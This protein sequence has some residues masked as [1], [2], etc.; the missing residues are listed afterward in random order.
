MLNPAHAKAAV[1]RE[2]IDRAGIAFLAILALAVMYAYLPSLGHGPRG[3]QWP[4]LM[5]MMHQTSCGDYI[6][7][8][9]S[10]NRTRVILPGDTAL[11]RPLLFAYL[12][13]MA[14]MSGTHVWIPQAAGI[15]LH[16]GVAGLAFTVLRGL[17]VE[18]YANS[19]IANGVAALAALYFATTP[20]IMEQVIWA[21]VNAYMLASLC[22]LG[23]IR[24]Q[25]D[26]AANDWIAPRQVAVTLALAVIACFTFEPALFL[27]PLLAL[28]AAAGW[29]PAGKTPATVR[30][31]LGLAMLYLAP[32]VVYLGAYLLDQHIHPVQQDPWMNSLG[33]RAAAVETLI[34][35]A[36]YL[37]YA[38]GY[39]FVA[40]KPEGYTG[41]RLFVSE[42]SAVRAVLAAVLLACLAAAIIAGGNAARHLSGRPRRAALL[43]GAIALGLLV[44]QALMF[45]V[46]RINPNPTSPTVLATSSY[47][48][49]APY[50][51][52]TLL[53]VIAS[54]CMTA[55]WTN[56]P[57]SARPRRWLVRM[58]IVLAVLAIGVRAG[59]VHSVN[60]QLARHLAPLVDAVDAINA[61]RARDPFATFRISAHTA[62]RLERFQGVPVLYTLFHHAIDQCGARYEILPGSPYVTA[63]TAASACYP[64]LVRP[65]TN[66]HYYFY[67]GEYFG[68]PFWFAFPNEQN[69]RDNPYVVLAPTLE[70]AM[71]GQPA[72]LE[73]LLHDLDEK[74]IH[75]PEVQHYHRYFRFH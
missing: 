36:R 42:P 46:G 35:L 23:I 72:R 59:L 50:L 51:A 26:A 32:A 44:A 22:V 20:A 2:G 24:V 62:D 40:G 5:D 8:S 74:R 56:R 17:L 43:A 1:G 7:H 11:F 64:I 18:I 41:I 69:V 9:Y 33:R 61:V 10:Y 57:G 6:S 53:L 30:S 71:L 38:V 16:L 28:C 13:L 68:L 52:A 73:R 27:P 54:A 29:T 49:Y 67:R 12:S 21:H 75:I 3:D 65:D 19:R 25:A 14:C 60:A 34:N 66:Y 55:R 70:A 31:R 48:S 58:V 4:F 39:P 47:Q 37:V 45:T 63:A 15:A